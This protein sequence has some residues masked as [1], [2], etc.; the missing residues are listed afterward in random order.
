M[1]TFSILF[2]DISI[3]QSSPVAKLPSNLVV[4]ALRASD[5]NMRFPTNMIHKIDLQIIFII[6]YYII[7]KILSLI[8]LGNGVKMSFE[9]KQ[10]NF[11]P[12][13]ILNSVPLD[14]AKLPQDWNHR[15]KENRLWFEMEEPADKDMMVTVYEGPKDASVENGKGKEYTYHQSG[16]RYP[17]MLLPGTYIITFSN[18]Q[19][20]QLYVVFDHNKLSLEE[21]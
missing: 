16:L 6:V 5:Q 13:N 11:T 3:D 17:H 9:I 4:E 15:C 7:M 19:Y 10:K 14:V 8:T 21:Y 2:V 20:T 1:N 18:D 12:L